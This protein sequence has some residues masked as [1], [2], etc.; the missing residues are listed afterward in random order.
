MTLEDLSEIEKRT[1]EIIKNAGEIEPKS[2]PERRMMGTIGSLKEKGLIE[3]I[4]RYTSW[5][6]KRKKKLVKVKQ[7]EA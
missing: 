7:T 5:H 1:Y 4:K 6:R 2:L 3:V